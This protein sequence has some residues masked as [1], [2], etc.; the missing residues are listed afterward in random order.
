MYGCTAVFLNTTNLITFSVDCLHR[1]GIQYQ[2]GYREVIMKLEKVQDRYGAPY[3]IASEPGQGKK[4]LC[5]A[6]TRPEAFMH[7]LQ[8]IKQ[9]GLDRMRLRA[10]K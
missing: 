7:C 1:S 8:V 10:V 3:W 9:Q 2:F 6:P 4:I 5:Y